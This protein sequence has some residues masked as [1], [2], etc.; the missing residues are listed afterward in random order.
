MFKKITIYDIAKMTGVSAKTVSKV[1]NYKDGVKEETRKKVLEMVEKLGYHPN[2]FA[3][4]LRANQPA[5]VG[6]TFPAPIDIIPF[7][8]NFFLWLFMELYRVF[9]KK[10]NIS[11]LICFLTN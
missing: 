10:G 9:G 8:P 6:V 4:S 1:I 7:S 11:V 2:I 5:C 3:R